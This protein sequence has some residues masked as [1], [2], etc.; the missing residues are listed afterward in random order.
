[1]K[2]HGK[3]FTAAKAKVDRAKEYS[4]GEAI[5]FLKENKFSKF[6]ETVD[7]CI[8]LGIDPAKSDQQIRG[9]VVM[10]NGLGK[11]VRILAFARGDAERTAKEAGAEHVG[12]DELVAKINEGW[13]DFDAVVATPDMMSVVG[14][15]GKVLG[16]RGLMPNPKTG[17]V[18][19]DIG[20]A[21]KE[22]KAGKSE[23]RVD[24]AGIIHA[25]VGKVSF[26]KEN[27]EENA[28]TF[29]DAIIRAKPHT[30]KGHYLRKIVLSSTMGPG[31]RISYSEA[32][33]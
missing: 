18:T 12:A 10:P 25:P 17:T 8:R 1:M 13:A 5:M 33:A 24:K 21:I 26:S 29:I 15:V 2:K 6:D 16:P 19:P 32:A 27:L 11:K 22:L 4:L 30:A 9:A 3:K 23:Y 28:R 14:K 7:V 31:L 20:R